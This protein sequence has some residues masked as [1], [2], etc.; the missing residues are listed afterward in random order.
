L[1][2]AWVALACAQP[3]M[4]DLG[5]PSAPSLPPVPT[6]TPPTA[7]DPVV[8][9]VPTVAPLPPPPVPQ[10]PDT[11]L[12]QAPGVPDV[13]G[14]SNLPSTPTRAPSTSQGGGG[15]PGSPSSSGRPGSASAGGAGGSAADGGSGGA[16]G[17]GAGAPTQ[18]GS[19]AP[20]SGGRVSGGAASARRT[21]VRQARRERRLRRTVHGLQS[22]LGSLDESPRRVLVLR[23]G[24]GAVAPQSRSRVARRLDISARRVARLERRGVRELRGL[25]AAGRCGGAGSPGGEAEARRAVADAAPAATFLQGLRVLLGAGP[26]ADRIEVDAERLSYRQRPEDATGATRDRGLLAS[27]RVRVLGVELTL[28]LLLALGFGA[29]A[30]AVHKVRRELGRSVA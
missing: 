28:P 5:L 9:A 11:S 13:T 10:L 24:I 25:A 1:T 26:W 23:A 16:G 7:L 12:P 14:G 21:A 3:A 29:L 2:I 6:V 17:G 8:D 15:A 27:P 30:L 18:A 22:C 4:A 19:G 20:A